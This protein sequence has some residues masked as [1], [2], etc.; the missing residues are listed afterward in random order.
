VTYVTALLVQPDGGILVG[1]DFSGFGDVATPG[2]V[3]LNS[4]GS[5][6]SS[7]SLPAGVGALAIQSLQMDKTGRILLIGGLESL[8]LESHCI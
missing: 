6:D 2:L 1:G 5:L 8:T 7:F 3:R 4:D